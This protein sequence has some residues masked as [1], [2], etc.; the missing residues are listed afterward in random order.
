MENPSSEHSS[1]A[2]ANWNP[3]GNALGQQELLRE[4]RKEEGNTTEWQLCARCCPEYYPCQSHSVPMGTLLD[5][6]PLVRK[7]RPEP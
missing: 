3:P 2:T 5:P 7:L 4:G 1:Q 6:I